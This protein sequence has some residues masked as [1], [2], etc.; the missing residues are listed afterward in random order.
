M[1][2]RV[3]LQTSEE[4]PEGQ[5]RASIVTATGVTG[6]YE[7]LDMDHG[8]EAGDSVCIVWI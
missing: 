5:E 7:L 4:V 1:C 8:Y 3:F 2:M 6:G